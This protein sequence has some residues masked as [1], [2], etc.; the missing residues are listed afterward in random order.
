MQLAGAPRWLQSLT[1][2]AAMCRLCL[3]EVQPDRLRTALEAGAYVLNFKGCAGCS[4]RAVNLKEVNR[5]AS[6]QVEEDEIESET[7]ESI[8]YSHAC[9]NCGHVVAVH[10]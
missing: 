2:H 1:A 3:L 4:Q 9:G 5:V 8:S 7:T 6:V 10:Q